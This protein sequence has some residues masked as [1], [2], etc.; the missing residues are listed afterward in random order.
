MSAQATVAAND[1]VTLHT[2]TTVYIPVWLQWHTDD[3]RCHRR[4][5][6]T[7]NHVCAAS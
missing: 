6:G 3:Q 1:V 5:A 7:V 2:E 4:R